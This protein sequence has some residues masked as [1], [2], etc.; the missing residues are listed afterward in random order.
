MDRVRQGEESIPGMGMLVLAAVARTHRYRVHLIDA[1]QHGTSI[2][3]VSRQIAALQPEYLGLSATTIS[4]TNASRIAERQAGHPS[5]VTILGGSHAPRHSRT[6]ARSISQ[7]DY[8]VGRGRNS[9]FVAGAARRAAHRSAPVWRTDG[10]GGV[11]ANPRAP[12]IDDPHSLPPPAWICCRIPAS[13]SADDVQLRQYAGGI[14]HHIA[15]AV[16]LHVL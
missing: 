4:V 7:H 3:D 1:K 12:Y 16:H 5:V 2:E 6:H 14:A 8:G 9:L 11:R 10:R 13:L 15:R